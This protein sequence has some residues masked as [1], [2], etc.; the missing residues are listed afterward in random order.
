MHMSTAASVSAGDSGLVHFLDH[1]SGSMP[2]GALP[3]VASSKAGDS[4]SR[5]QAMLIRCFDRL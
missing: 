4:H 5:N 3:H 2:S 1:V